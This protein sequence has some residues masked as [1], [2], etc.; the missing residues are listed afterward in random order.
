MCNVQFWKGN[1]LCYRSSDRFFAGFAWD[2]DSG[3]WPLPDKA[4]SWHRHKGHRWQL[5]HSHLVLSFLVTLW[6]SK[7]DSWECLSTMLQLC[8]GSIRKEPD[9]GFKARR[10][11]D[12]GS[13][14]Q[15]RADCRWPY[16]GS[17]WVSIRGARH[18]PLQIQRQKSSFRIVGFFF[19]QLTPDEMSIIAGISRWSKHKCSFSSLGT[20]WSQRGIDYGNGKGGSVGG[21]ADQ[22][23]ICRFWFDVS[24]RNPAKCQHR[25]QVPV[26]PQS[27]LNL[28]GRL[29]HGDL[30]EILMDFG[31]AT[32]ACWK[33]HDRPE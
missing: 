33:N 2:T 11:W 16:K 6:I 13:L 25:L 10:S 22:A 30:Q 27:S 31:V 17:W 26:P 28:F 32:R 3:C 21:G 19:N 29:E 1:I 8:A 24:C 23:S 14:G 5:D 15:K 4:T 20:R 12:W 7:A 9:W 18:L